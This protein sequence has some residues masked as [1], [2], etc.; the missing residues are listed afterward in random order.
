MARVTV[1][2]A[3]AMGTAMAMHL[4]RAGN[5][6]ALWASQHDAAVLPNL[7]A[8]RRHPAL[9]EHLP[10]SLVIFGPA[11][12]DAACENVEIGVMGAHSGGARTLATIVVERATPPLVVG[13]AKGLEPKT[14]RRVSEV[15][16]EVVGHD[17]VVAIG[18]PCLAAELA[19]GLPTAVVFASGSLEPGER[20]A[21]RFRTDAFHVQ[22][23]D[24]LPG[25]EYCMVAKNVAAVGLGIL[26]GM[27]SGVGFEYR[28]AKA[29]LFARAFRELETLIVA[30]GGRPETV[31]G[32][33]GLGD[34]LVTALG[35]RNRLYGQMLG[36]GAEPSVARK[37]LERR[38]MTVEG[39][40]SSRE[41]SALAAEH[42]L[43]LAFFTQIH[44]ILFEGTP[45]ATVLD[46]V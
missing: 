32:L 9:P 43:D 3:G 7:L 8:E 11:D 2:G 16:A 4:A 26:D 20:C 10:D 24:D 36:E 45:P 42:G 40:D 5:D 22:V 35:G 34:A 28:N 27:G 30:L 25:V 21:E 13:I 19:Q 39:V 41:V 18:G 17:R 23:S 6:T 15:Y 14:H 38:G 37:E 33:A 46:Y 1:F 12:L 29:A 31:A 44:R